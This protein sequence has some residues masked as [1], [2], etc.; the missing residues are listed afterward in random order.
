MIDTSEIVALWRHVTALDTE[1]ASNQAECG[2]IRIMMLGMVSIVAIM[3][4]AVLALSLRP[5]T[6]VHH[7][8]HTCEAKP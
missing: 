2:R 7:Y 4:G 8:V 3:G 5:P 6:A 1:F